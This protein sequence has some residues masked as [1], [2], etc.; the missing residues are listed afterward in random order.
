MEIDVNEYNDYGDYI[1]NNQQ[2]IY[3]T[4]MMKIQKKYIYAPH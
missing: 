4:E 1:Y 2:L 3:V